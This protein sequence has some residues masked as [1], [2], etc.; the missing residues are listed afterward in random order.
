ECSTEAWNDSS[1]GQIFFR[2]CPGSRDCSDKNTGVCCPDEADCT[3][4][5]SKPAH[6]ANETWDLFGNTVDG[7]Y[8]CCEQGKNGFRSRVGVGCA[9]KGDPTHS[10]AQML[11]VVSPGK[12]QILLTRYEPNS[13]IT[14]RDPK[15]EQ[16]PSIDSNTG[17]IAGGVVGGVAGLAI[18]IALFWYFMRCRSQKQPPQEETPITEILMIQPGHVQSSGKPSEL[19]GRGYVTEL[20]S[21]MENT[22]IHELPEYSRTR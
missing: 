3:Q 20:P 10:D 14:R 13:D 2:C 11:S 22:P 7:G 1:T 4:T 19:D 16:L 9:G 12:I 18:I 21:C 15:V 5:I 6:C 8:F 17:A